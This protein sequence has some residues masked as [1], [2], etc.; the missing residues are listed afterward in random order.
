MMIRNLK[1]IKELRQGQVPAVAIGRADQ[2]TVTNRPNRRLRP[3]KTEL[4]QALSDSGSPAAR[5]PRALGPSPS[6]RAAAHAA[7]DTG[8]GPPRARPPRQTRVRRCPRRRRQSSAGSRLARASAAAG[9][10]GGTF[11][12]SGWTPRGPPSRSLSIYPCGGIRGPP[13]AMGCDLLIHRL[14][15]AGSYLRQR[16]T[17]LLGLRRPPGTL[18]E[19]PVAD[20]P[21][22]RVGL[23]PTKPTKPRTVPSQRGATRGLMWNRTVGRPPSRAMTASGRIQP[24]SRRHSS[25]SPTTRGSVSPVQSLR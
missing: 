6:R 9:S 4:P 5:P 17:G 3:V 14:R 1:A 15:R 23:E 12:G 16:D 2:V 13:E 22:S 18:S 10:E 11:H 20:L 21:V 25:A 24:S 19:P 7:P 8:T